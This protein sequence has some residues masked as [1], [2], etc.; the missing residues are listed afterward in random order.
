METHVAHLKTGPY[1]SAHLCMVTCMRGVVNSDGRTSSKLQA[2]S[3]TSQRVE[4]DPHS[5]KCSAYRLPTRGH[6]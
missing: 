5:E 3:T 2:W 6:C 4:A 1:F